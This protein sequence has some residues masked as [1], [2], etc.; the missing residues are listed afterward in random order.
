M[1]MASHQII[2]L[3]NTYLGVQPDIEIHLDEEEDDAVESCVGASV[4]PRPTLNVGA[5]ALPLPSET[6]IG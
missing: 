1:S 4:K 2:N 3:P 5:I 6:Y